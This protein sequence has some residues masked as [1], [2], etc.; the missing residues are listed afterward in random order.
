MATW[1]IGDVQGC[2]KSLRKLLDA[3][4]FD[5]AADRAWFVG[6]LVNRGPASLAALRIVMDLRA[7]AVV[8]LGNHDLHLLARAEG[9]AEAKRRDT[10]DDVLHAPDRDEILAW[11]RTR[12]LLHRAKGYVLVHAG[13]PP[14]W[15][16]RGA[17][18]RARAAER[19][20]RG[21]ARGT[22]LRGYRGGRAG[23]AVGR[24]ASDA[25]ALTTIR[26][27]DPRGR[28]SNGFSGPPGEAPPGT[29][30]WYRARGAD[31]RGATIVFGHWAAL[32]WLS[33]PG[34]LALDTGCVWGGK[35]TAV[36]LEDRRRVA[37]PRAD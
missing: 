4:R 28:P 30:P 25:L 12:P 36:R 35:L 29:R 5:P 9:V 22:F 20:L 26:V 10:L 23:G 31:P 37:V 3:I 27:V 34:F 32:G 19:A 11:L 8:V 1:A 33:E 14:R 15:T 21:P 17:E 18:T 13:I 24:A 7:A 16:L 6:D 2:A